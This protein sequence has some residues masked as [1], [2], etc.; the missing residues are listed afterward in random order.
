MPAIAVAEAALEGGYADKVLFVGAENGLEK[1]LVPTFGYSIETLPVGRVRGMSVTTKIK[2]LSGLLASVP[3]AVRLL[4]RFGADVVVGTGGYASA[5]TLMAGRILGLRTVV[6]EQNTIPGATTR[7]LGK[8]ADEICVSFPMTSGYLPSWKVRLTGN[9]VRHTFIAAR[10]RRENRA[11]KETFNILVL[12]GSQGA[13]FLN[14]EVASCLAGLA[15]LHSDVF[16][17]HQAGGGR[18]DEA[19]EAYQGLANCQV[20]GFIDD[21]AARLEQADL[22]V[23]RA[24]ATT[25][26]ELGVVGVPSLLI[27]FPFATDNHQEWNARALQ[28]AGAAR[29][30]LQHNYNEHRFLQELESLKSSRE[31]LTQMEKAARLVGIPDAAYR[32][33]EVVRGGK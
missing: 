33:M 20:V 27:P 13:L 30:Y 14:S 18:T 7:L 29:M 9:P 11:H 32:V 12:G 1:K 6:L 16:V 10:D 31:T 5:P 17:L 3:V 2:G 15:R 24:G 4:K 28:K 25:V 8:V 19:S 21:M 22:V 26:A 23:S